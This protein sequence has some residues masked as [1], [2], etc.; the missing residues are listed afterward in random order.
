MSIIFHIA[1]RAVWE[2]A[3]SGGYY[4]PPS[5]ISDG[6]IHCSTIE[7]TTDTADQY[8]AGQLDLVLLCIDTDKVEVR[9]KYE[10]PA[11]LNDQRAGSLFPH[12]YGPLEV[13][14]VVRAVEFAPG[15]DGKFK[16]PA[17]IL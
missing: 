2:A 12:I 5:L 1:R 17:G 3:V 14:A 15:P 4:M 9:I 6:F 11:C 16:L 8:Y 13:S 10:A 7:Q